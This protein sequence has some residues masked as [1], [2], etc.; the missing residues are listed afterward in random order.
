MELAVSLRISGKKGRYNIVLSM[1]VFFLSNSDV[2]EGWR[3]PGVH[4]VSCP[5]H[6]QYDYM[7]QKLWELKKLANWIKFKL[8]KAQENMT[9]KCGHV[10]QEQKYL[11]LGNFSCKLFEKK[12]YFID[13]QHGRLVTWLKTKN[14]PFRLAFPF[15]LR[16]LVVIHLNY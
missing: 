1:R 7:Q 14:F 5:V 12:F 2:V 9:T 10:G 11:S 4:F 6:N 13:P 16:C 3:K 8:L 15:M